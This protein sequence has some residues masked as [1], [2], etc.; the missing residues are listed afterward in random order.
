MRIGLLVLGASLLGG[1]AG[2]QVGIEV[3]PKEIRLAGLTPGGRAVVFG[4]GKGKAQGMPA[5]LRC[6]RVAEVTEAK[7]T[8]VFPPCAFQG[9]VANPIPEYS[10]WVAIDVATGEIA[11]ASPAGPM[12]VEKMAAVAAGEP[13]RGGRFASL[14]LPGGAYELLLVRPGVGVWDATIVDGLTGDDDGETDGTVV[15]SAAT[16]RQGSEGFP[17][18]DAFAPGDRVILMDRQYF[19]VSEGYVGGQP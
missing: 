7:G 19:A 14:R 13:L 3:A 8:V 10:A 5:L 15:L 12:A 11:A 16:P 18:L 17:R 1:S 6:L 9:R 4:L 2:A